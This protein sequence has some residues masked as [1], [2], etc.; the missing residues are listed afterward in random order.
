MGVELEN[1]K[2]SAAVEPTSAMY[3]ANKMKL[4]IFCLNISG[5]MVMSEAAPNKLSWPDTVAVAQAADEAGWEFLLSLGRWRGHGGRF[6]ANAEQY[7]TFTW[8]AGMAALTKR[9]HLFVTCHIPVYHPM[10]AAKMTATIDAISA[11]RVGLNVVAGNNAIEFG[12]FGIDQHAH[13]DRYA[14]A[15]EWLTIAERLWSEDEE[16]DWEG[17]F[18]T[19]RRGYLQPKPVQRPRPLIVSAGTSKVGLDFALTRA[20]FSFQG[21]PDIEFMRGVAQRTDERARELGVRGGRLTYAPVVLADTEKEAW[22]YF[23]WY[24]DEMGDI[25]AAKNQIRASL[26]GGSQ[27]FTPEYHLQMARA[28]VAGWG[29]M[30]LVGTAEQITEKLV[31][32]HELGYDGIALGWVDMGQGLAEFNEKVVPLMVEAGLREPHPQA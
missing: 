13:D 18:Y 10:L 32:Y 27:T 28:K 3:G 14:A 15:E 9:I 8:A 5:G 31:T 29:G 12:M 19:V 23:N 7:E 2:G 25:E 20:D 17:R 11:G 21:G 26:A 30:P 4:G 22:R 6:N 24:V 16:L 1:P